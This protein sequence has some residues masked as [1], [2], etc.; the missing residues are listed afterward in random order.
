MYLDF[1]SA[2]GKGER[3]YSVEERNLIQA[4]LEALY[5]APFSIA[6]TQ[7]A[8]AIGRYTTIMINGGEAE[9]NEVL[10]GGAAYELDWRNANAGSRAD[11]NVNPFLGRTGQ[12]AASPENF[13]ALT[14]TVA[15]HELGHLLGLRHSDAFGPIG[16]NPATGLPYGV[17]AGLA[18]R[19]RAV[20][21]IDP[22]VAGAG[23]TAT[24]TFKRG[25]V[26]VAPVTP[27][28]NLTP[29]AFSPPAGTIYDA[30]TPVA[31]FTVDALG[32]V[33]LTQAGTRVAAATFDPTTGALVLTWDVR[34]AVSSV[35][36]TYHYDALRPGY[37][38]PDDAAETDR[39][40]M[41]SP[42]SVGSSIADALAN[43]VWG[44]RELIKLAYADASS[45]R[46]EAFLGPTTAAPPARTS[47]P[48]A[49]PPLMTI[50]VYQ[51]TAGAVWVKA[52][53]NGAA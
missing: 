38:G 18:A 16:V 48:S 5:T 1:D 25:P 44:E 3:A 6:F 45:T 7:T 34:P 20:N 36:V 10:A 14:A 13:I 15:A 31:T 28:G 52:M 9:G 47:F 51:P 41:A 24:Y 35:V 46:V 26:L 49:S 43:P 19:S 4:R 21:E 22:G 50:V 8:P 42:A 37:R 32:Q 23:T 17:S 2:T 53:L 11:V 39:H 12:P 40:V 33:L 29:N 30:V 27:A